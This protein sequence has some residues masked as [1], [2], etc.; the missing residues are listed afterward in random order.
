[1]KAGRPRKK[2]RTIFGITYWSCPKPPPPRDERSGV[3]KQRKAHWV[4]E[5]KMSKTRGRV[6][7]YCCDCRNAISKRWRE[8]NPE[9]WAEI[10]EAAK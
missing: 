9:R 4:A 6:H 7:T 3:R 8:E 2:P 5:A 1:M 10:R